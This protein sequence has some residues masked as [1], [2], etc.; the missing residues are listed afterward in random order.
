MPDVLAYDTPIRPIKP[1]DRKPAPAQ[2]PS[3]A[4]PARSTFFSE[5]R[6]VLAGRLGR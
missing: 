1:A 2:C 4:P 3:D 6:K 5:W